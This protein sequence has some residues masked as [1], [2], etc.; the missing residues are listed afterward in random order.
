M[1]IAVVGLG[2]VGLPTA[3]LFAQSGFQVIGFD[4]DSQKLKALKNGRLPFGENEPGLF[5]LFLSVKRKKNQFHVT[6]DRF[7]LADADVF[8][9]AVDTPIDERTKKPNPTSLKLALETVGQVMKVGS[10]IIVE[11]TIAPLTME[12]VVIPILER[13]SKRKVSQDFSVLHCPERIT[14]GKTLHNLM[15]LDRVIGA[16]TEREGRIGKKLYQH[17]CKG[18]IDIVSL[19]TAEV[20][21]TAENAQRDV[22]IAFSNEL[23]QICDAYG[24]DFSRVKELIERV[25]NRTLLDPGAGVG[26]HCLPKDSWLLRAN[27]PHPLEPSLITVARSINDSMPGYILVLLEKVFRSLHQTVRG[28]KVT[29]LGYAYREDTDDSRMSPT[30]TLRKLLKRRGATV[31]IHDPFVKGF[32]R[33]FDRMVKNADA[34][35]VM[36]GHSTSKQPHLLRK[37]KTLM[38]GNVLIDGRHI[39]SKT[40]AEKLGFIFRG[41]GHHE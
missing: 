29:L 10:T 1:N 37:I 27:L 20:I 24:V 21:K 5:D 30:E 17:F 12:K 9:I 35:I 28:K 26:G 19:K 32:E 38:K 15:Y 11:S 36:V 14:P 16:S 7:S 3:L 8:L 6:D 2:Y 25:P 41:V 13:F 18:R 31:S 34:V 39:F 23:S 22:E 4:K 40:K 33:D